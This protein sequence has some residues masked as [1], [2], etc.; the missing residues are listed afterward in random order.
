MQLMYSRMLGFNLDF[1]LFP[2]L[3]QGDKAVAQMLDQLNR[4]R[5][6]ARH[7]DLVVII[8]GGGGEVGLAAFNN[9]LLAQSIAQF[10]IPIFTG[11]GHATNLTVS[12]MVAHTN[13]ITPSE[14]ADIL[15]NQFEFFKASIVLAQKSLMM[16]FQVIDEERQQLERQLYYL[17]V[18]AEKHLENRKNKLAALKAEMLLIGQKRLQ[19]VRNNLD[20]IQFLL[21]NSGAKMIEQHGTKMDVLQKSISQNASLLL[22]K[23]KEY[24]ANLQKTIELLRPENVLKRGYS[25][26]YHQGKLIA[27]SA[28][29]TEGDKIETVLAKGSFTSTVVTKSTEKIKK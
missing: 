11:I 2:S 26:S 9:Y 23:N 18:R 12:E 6:V 1:H 24:L 7:F 3:L 15:L 14:L 8:R 27:D 29:L 22:S 17:Q 21:Q 25:L 4:I 5:M 10:P 16:A 13:A 19:F 20:H 28:D